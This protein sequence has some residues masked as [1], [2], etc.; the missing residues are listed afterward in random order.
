[1]RVSGLGDSGE[2]SCLANVSVIAAMLRDGFKY[3]WEVP[4]GAEG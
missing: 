1:M 3:V 2:H 4:C